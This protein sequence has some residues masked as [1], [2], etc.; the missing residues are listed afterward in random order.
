[1]A[2]L[3]P[4]CNLARPRDHH[5]RTFWELAREAWDGDSGRMR[6]KTTVARHVRNVRVAF[7]M[8]IK[9]IGGGRT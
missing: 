8:G 1:M 9:T 3:R 2:A 5:V 7:K 6:P 4:T